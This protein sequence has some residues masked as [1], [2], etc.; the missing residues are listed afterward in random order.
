MIE[1]TRRGDKELLNP[2]HVVRAWWGG[3]CVSI[4]LVT[5]ETLDVEESY[6]DVKDL[7]IHGRTFPKEDKP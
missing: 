7:L 4:Q 2:D 6:N 5:G 3:I 1:I